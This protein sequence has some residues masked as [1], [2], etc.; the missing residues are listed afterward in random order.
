M[1]GYQYERKWISKGSG[2]MRKQILFRVPEETYEAAV[3]L[4]NEIGISFNGLLNQALRVYLQQEALKRFTGI[5]ATTTEEEFAER[6][7]DEKHRQEGSG[8]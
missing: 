4:A 5:V 7:L 1:L 3:I 6:Y 8:R 2:L